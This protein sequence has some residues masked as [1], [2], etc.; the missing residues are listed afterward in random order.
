MP[1]ARLQK[2]VDLTEEAELS[3]LEGGHGDALDDARGSSPGAG[4]GACGQ[5]AT[6]AGAASRGEKEGGGGQTESRQT[7]V[8]G[9]AEHRASL[10]EKKKYRR[11][12]KIDRRP[13]QR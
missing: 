5:P 4:T 9:Y 7:L 3:R 2:D 13:R 8:S 11:A 10:S 6:A 12:I 1:Y